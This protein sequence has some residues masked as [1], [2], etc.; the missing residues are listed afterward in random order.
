M[1]EINPFAKEETRSLDW[2][3][4][5]KKGF[6]DGRDYA[7]AAAPDLLAALEGLLNLTENGGDYA[8]SCEHGAGLVDA[9]IDAARA[10]IAR[11]THS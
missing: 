7:R 3:K 10:A 6:Q 11:A 5:Y 2:V 9:R 8:L 1:E 4:G